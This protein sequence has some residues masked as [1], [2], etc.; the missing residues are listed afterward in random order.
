MSKEKRL[1]TDENLNEQLFEKIKYYIAPEDNRGGIKSPN[2]IREI[3]RDIMRQR[4]INSCK[5]NKDY[6][7]DSFDGCF[8]VDEYNNKYSLS[9]F[10]NFICNRTLESVESAVL[11]GVHY[12]QGEDNE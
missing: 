10:Y 1:M 6:L 12:L 8:I 7:L 2:R 3:N 5:E 4:F 9:D 11:V